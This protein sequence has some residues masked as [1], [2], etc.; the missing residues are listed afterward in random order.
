MVKN[1]YKQPVNVIF[2]KTRYK[3]GADINIYLEAFSETHLGLEALANG[4]LKTF[5]ELYFLTRYYF[6]RKKEYINE[7][8]YIKDLLNKNTTV[9]CYGEVLCGGKV[10]RYLYKFSKFEFS[11][12]LKKVINSKYKEVSQKFKDLGR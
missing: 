4:N 1:F 8:C 12:E 5:N 7:L 2:H 10:S 9:E 3:L 6:N 11:D